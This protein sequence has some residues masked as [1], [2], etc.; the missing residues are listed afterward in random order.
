MM[1]D[2]TEMLELLDFIILVNRLCAQISENLLIPAFDP[3][4]SRGI[5]RPVKNRGGSS[6]G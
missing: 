6:S 4:I 2:L 1:M 5:P 3:P